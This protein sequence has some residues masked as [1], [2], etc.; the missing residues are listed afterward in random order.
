MTTPLRHHLAALTGLGAGVLVLW[1]GGAVLPAEALDPTQWGSRPASDP[2]LAVVAGVRMIGL[3][4]GTWLTTVTVLS[5]IAHLARSVT[6]GRLAASLAPAFWRTMVLRPVT[7]GLL[8]V[9]P[10]LA[11]VSISPVA[12]HA[13]M[14][15]S[16]V[17]VS[18]R[19][20]P[21]AEMR[22]V[23]MR[24][25]E[26]R[27][28]DDAAGPADGV[29]HDPATVDALVEPPAIDEAPHLADDPTPAMPSGTYRVAVG[30]NLWS[31]AAENLRAQL[32]HR[33]S[34]AEV[35][36]HWVAI[37]DANRERLPDASNPDLIHPGLE[38]VLPARG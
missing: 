29:D 35:T 8:A 1:F 2:V 13:A 18:T 25:L 21:D 38:I 23:T 14:D 12:A 31:I 26:P 36:R 16:P 34:A 32:G 33:P 4:L 20:P 5:T 27:T 37:I 7:A 9:P 6:L 17:D 22:T 10:I 24:W 30:D 28:I 3:I 15:P 19:T 11:P